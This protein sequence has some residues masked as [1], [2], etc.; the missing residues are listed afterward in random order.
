MTFRFPG[1]RDELR[2]VLRLLSWRMVTGAACQAA[3]DNPRNMR[4]A[5]VPPNPN[6]FVIA[7]SIDN[8]TQIAPRIIHAIV[9]VEWAVSRSRTGPASNAWTLV[10]RGRTL[11]EWQRMDVTGIVSEQRSSGT[12]L[13]LISAAGH[14]FG[15]TG[16]E[17]GRN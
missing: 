16:E 9:G 6:E 11:Q 4:D 13:W 1:R 15:G 8:C 3:Y 12:A 5:F 7:Y 2:R 17:T 10:V 14:E